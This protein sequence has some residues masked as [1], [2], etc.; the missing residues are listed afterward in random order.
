MDGGIRRGSDIVKALALGAQAVLVGRATLFG[1]CAA[2]E[3][4]ARRALEILAEELARTM[5]L[6][7]AARVTDIGP[8]L[9]TRPAR[10]ARGSLPLAT[11]LAG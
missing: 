6:C 10:A 1:A 7:G 8:Q 5:R 3:P 11:P 4:G 2:G 9:L